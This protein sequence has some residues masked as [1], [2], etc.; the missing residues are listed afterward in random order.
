M[1]MFFWKTKT[2]QALN[3]L[4]VKNIGKDIL[5]LKILIIKDHSSLNYRPLNLLFRFTDSTMAHPYIEKDINSWHKFLKHI[6]AIKYQFL[7]VTKIMYPY[8]KVWRFYVHW[9]YNCS[10][11][12][13]YQNLSKIFHWLM[14]FNFT[15]I[16]YWHLLRCLLHAKG[17][18]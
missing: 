13:F 18:D 3:F 2:V 14:Y 11:F 4:L 12:N 16:S 10:P 1:A 17:S 6:L 7:K 15:N 5:D 9:P 8:L